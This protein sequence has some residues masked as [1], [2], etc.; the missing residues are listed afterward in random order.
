MNSKL[1][2]DIDR[3]FSI[4]QDRIGG[5][6]LPL[7][8]AARTEMEEELDLLRTSIQNRLEEDIK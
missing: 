2:H 8:P 1:Q 5:L 7:S 6:I 4:Y 3:F